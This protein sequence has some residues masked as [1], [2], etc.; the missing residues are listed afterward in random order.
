MRHAPRIRGSHSHPSKTARALSHPLRGMSQGK[1]HGRLTRSNRALQTRDGGTTRPP[2]SDSRCVSQS[3]GPQPSG[4]AAVLSAPHR[5]PLSLTTPSLLSMGQPGF[6]SGQKDA[7]ASPRGRRG[8]DRVSMDSAKTRAAGSLSN[9]FSPR[10]QLNAPA[11]AKSAKGWAT[12]YKRAHPPIP[13][14]VSAF[15][16]RFAGSRESHRLRL[17]RIP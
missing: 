13:D 16:E 6:V 17:Y 4:D 7:W 15:R 1:N 2:L 12:H 14:R 11:F 5:K 9:P 8:G 3:S 10:T